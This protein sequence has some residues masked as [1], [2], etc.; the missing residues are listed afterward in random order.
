MNESAA[1]DPQELGEIIE[2]AKVAAKRYR[3]LTGRPL[4]VTGEIGEYEAVRLLG[5]RLAPVRQ[6]DYDAE[7]KDGANTK[8]VQIK[9]RCILPGAKPG[10]RVGQIRLDREWDSVVLVLLDEDLEAFEIYEASRQAIEEALLAPG[11]K[12]RNQRGALSVRKFK[13]IGELVWS[14]E[15]TSRR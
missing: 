11:S 12:A 10:Q 9:T 15:R 2:L 7:R 6:P 13:S 4:G 3:Q 5:L 1:I 14:R 8:R